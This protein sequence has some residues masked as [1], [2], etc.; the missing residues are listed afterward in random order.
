MQRTKCVV[1]ARIN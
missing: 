1:F